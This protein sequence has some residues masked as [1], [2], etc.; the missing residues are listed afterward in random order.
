MEKWVSLHYMYILDQG[1]GL[2]K[3]GKS[4]INILDKGSNCIRKLKSGNT[5]LYKYLRFHYLNYL[6]IICCR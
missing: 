2:K 3:M 4:L 1:G 6:I 5:Y